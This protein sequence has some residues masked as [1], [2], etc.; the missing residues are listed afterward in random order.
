MRHPEAKPLYLFAPAPLRITLAGKALQVER[1][2]RAPVFYP[3]L[4]IARI[5]VGGE[6]AEWGPGAIEACLE[7]GIPIVFAPGRWLKGWTVPLHRRHGPLARGLLEGMQTRAVRNGIEAWHR[8]EE[9]RALLDLLEALDVDP[10]T[11]DLRPDA[12]WEWAVA[13]ID[14]QG[15]G[16]IRQNLDALEPFLTARLAEC[17]VDAGAPPET[18]YTDRETG[19][20]RRMW[21][22]LRWSL[23]RLMLEA[24][25]PVSVP[26]SP[27]ETARTFEAWRP[28][29]D[30]RIDDLIEGLGQA[31]EYVEHRRP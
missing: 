15:D 20:M 4:R 21:R 29:L 13:C 10:A 25:R 17:L 26:L 9:R 7:F 19:L 5:V 16:V 22:I 2:D 11:V 12:C 1:P 14:R 8:A 23:L 31:L 3:L 28:A 18:L 24:R 27:N 6:S 30:L